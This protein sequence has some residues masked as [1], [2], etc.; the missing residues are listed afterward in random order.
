MDLTALVNIVEIK[1]TDADQVVLNTY[2]MAV[3][4][5]GRAME[6]M[7]TLGVVDDPGRSHALDVSVSAYKHEADKMVVCLKRLGF[8]KQAPLLRS[9]KRASRHSRGRVIDVQS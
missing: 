8:P 2:L 3:H 5:A 1:G 7:V 9:K 4:K 6:A